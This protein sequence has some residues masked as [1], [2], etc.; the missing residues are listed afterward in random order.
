MKDCF[1]KEL[2]IGDSVAYPG[3]SGS[4]MWMNSG[5]I[6]EILDGSLKI[7]RKYR[8]RY[9]EVDEEHIKIVTVT[10]TDRVIKI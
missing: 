5:E 9:S 2:N 3:R 4:C 7:F 10:R 1:G 8:R 6:K